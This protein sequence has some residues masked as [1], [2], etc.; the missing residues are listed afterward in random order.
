MSHVDIR[1][2]DRGD[3]V[4]LARG[5]AAMALETEGKHLDLEK[6]EEGVRGLRNQPHYGFYVVAELDGRPAAQMMITYEWS[7]WRNKVFWWIQS[8]YVLPACRQRG[9]YRAMHEWI[10]DEAAKSGACGLRLY[11]EKE[12]AGAQKTYARCGMHPSSYVMFEQYF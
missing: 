8:V 5:N 2:A 3:V 9:L 7:D 10:T 12:N 1:K 4:F 11:V 6:L